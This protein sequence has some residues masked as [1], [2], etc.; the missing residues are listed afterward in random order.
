MEGLL[1]PT[2]LLFIL[3]VIVI[4]MVSSV[5]RSRPG[6][7]SWSRSLSPRLKMFVFGALLHEAY[8]LFPTLVTAPTS[9]SYFGDFRLHLLLVLRGGV[10]AL[11]LYEII[12][13]TRSRLNSATFPVYILGVW[14]VQGPLSSGL[15]LVTMAL[16]G[17]VPNGI[18][19]YY[20]SPMHWLVPGMSF[21]YVVFN[22][23]A[24]LL[25]VTVAYYLIFGSFPRSFA[26]GFTTVGISYGGTSML[27]DETTRLLCASAWTGGHGFR[28]K[29]L[30]CYEEGRSAAAPEVGLD[31][32][33]ITQVC[34][35]AEDREKRYDWLFLLIGLAAAIVAAAVAPEL[36]VAVA[37]LASAA[38]FLQKS[39]Q[40]QGI[41]RRYFQRGKFDA[42]AVT[43]RLTAPLNPEVT[44]GFPAEGQNLIVYQGFAP[45]VGA[46]SNLG[47]W[48]FTVDTHKPREQ[49]LDGAQAPQAVRFESDEL[50]TAIDRSIQSLGLERLTIR[51]FCFVNGG[52]IREDRNI[53]PNVYGRPLQVLDSAAAAGYRKTSDSR[54]RHYQWISI[55]DW[56]NELVMS[57]FLR[58]ALRG[59]T[60]F[61]E[62]NRFLLTPLVDTC[63][64][65]DKLPAS[66]WKQKMAVAAGALLLGPIWVI[67][68]AFVTLGK[69]A[70]LTERIFDTKERNRRQ[71]IDRN[72]LYN[73]GAQ[74]SI[75]QTFSSAYF[76]HYFQKLD[77]DFY[78]KVLE[79]EIL[80]S[81]VTFLDEH[82]IDTSEIRER[83][84]LI[85]NSGI[86][87][88]GGDVTAESLAVGAG[89]TAVKTQP[90][91]RAKK[92]APKAKGAGA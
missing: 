90:A 42:S 91:E 3:L 6:K 52:D 77:G 67:R 17:R 84:A 4:F 32:G 51:D 79:N 83:R 68:A 40:E 16:Q 87:V 71:E 5:R 60:L 92:T 70:K 23:L 15:Y 45:F 20:S 10:S 25:T 13:R 34:K 61:V 41:L 30:D 82:D 85:L 64:A 63:H 39:L 46:G 21:P 55:N 48:S 7:A 65:I 11:V 2:H 26:H 47:G 38:L 8:F 1:Q 54:I 44:G 62:I 24:A 73:Y 19:S 37:V 33:L 72:P 89:A 56:G 80:D 59:T 22:L 28:K 81:I 14:Y 69:F 86:I 74:T 29:V 43:G 18:K 35:F 9:P 75:R 57:Y 88:Q 78:T 53:L 31:I 58:C 50:Y 49:G 12:W 36:G 27:S 76:S 66:N